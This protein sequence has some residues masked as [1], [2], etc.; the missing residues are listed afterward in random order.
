MGLQPVLEPH[1]KV[2]L[3]V[4]PLVADYLHAGEEL[5][6]CPE[7]EGCQSKENDRPEDGDAER[8]ARIII[9]KMLEEIESSPFFKFAATITYNHENDNARYG[10]Q[11]DR[12]FAEECAA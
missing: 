7:A 8:S 9:V 2:L 4:Y 1:A 6:G 10:C 3:D 12:L 5:V 11:D